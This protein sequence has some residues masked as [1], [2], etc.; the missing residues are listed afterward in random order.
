A[1]P[2]AEAISDFAAE[3]PGRTWVFGGGSVVTAGL[4][5]GAVDTLDI[6][7]MPEAIGEGIPLFTEPYDGPMRVIATQTYDYGGVRVVYDT[8][9]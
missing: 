4:L 6:T 2:T 8:S 7:I 1:A 5:G 3:T 9:T